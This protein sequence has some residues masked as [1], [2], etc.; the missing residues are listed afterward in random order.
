[1]RPRAHAPKL[2]IMTTPHSVDAALI[3]AP[4]INIA[5]FRTAPTP[6]E[7]SER[8]TT[9]FGDRLGDITPGKN[10][11]SIMVELDDSF[12]LHYQAVDT[13]PTRDSYG[14]HPIL[15]ADA[16]GLD[17]ATAQ[18]L[19]SVLPQETEH[20]RAKQFREARREHL[21][22]LSKATAVVAE[23]PD[24]LIVHNPRG[25]VS[26][27]PNT[28]LEAVRDN[29]AP[30]HIAPV[31]LTQ[32]EN[33]ILGYTVGLVQAG[34]PEIQAATKSMD[35]TDLYYKLANIADHVLQ[36]ATV[37]DGDTLSFEQGQPPLTVQKE[38]WFVDESYPAVTI[39]F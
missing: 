37:K 36:G 39:N 28:F 5:V 18:I 11:G 24:C 4:L 17:S 33:K 32:K 38:P 35:P 29:L 10:P 14:L 25:N 27:A 19:V 22:L 13:P 31:W 15:S 30:M 1:M 26:I 12:L 7:V 6:E 2:N 16:R 34:H 9:T 21:E 8:L 3:D 20:D 23:H